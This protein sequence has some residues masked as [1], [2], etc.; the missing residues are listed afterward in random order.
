MAEAPMY[1]EYATDADKV[2]VYSLRMKQGEE[3]LDKWAPRARKHWQR[4]EA[5]QRRTRNN[6]SSGGHI[7][8]TPL[9]ISNID[10]LYSSMTAVEVDVLTTPEGQTTED[11]AYI[12]T[13]A[14][15]EEW[16]RCKVQERGSEVTKDALI[17]GIGYGK[18]GYEYFEAEQEVPRADEDIRAD[19]EELL[20][21]AGEAG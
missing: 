2:K 5:L 1:R 6:T 17:V 9:A 4:Y 13:A 19:I 14:L 3:A 12:A 15:S 20:S 16:E 8:Q 21:Q 18:G 11:Q 10:S 7:I